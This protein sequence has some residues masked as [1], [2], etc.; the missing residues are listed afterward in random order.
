MFRKQAFCLAVFFYALVLSWTGSFSACAEEPFGSKSQIS[1]LLERDVASVTVIAPQENIFVGKPLKVFKY[2]AKFSSWEEQKKAS[3]FDKAGKCEFSLPSG[4]FRIEV[5]TTRNKGEILCARSQSFSVARNPVIVTLDKVQKQTVLL[6][7]DNRLVAINELAVASLGRSE[8]RWKSEKGVKTVSLFTPVGEELE[9]N[10][11]GGNKKA[12]I[13]GW[14]TFKADRKM[15]ISTEDAGWHATA[16]EVRSQL[17]EEGN[18]L[19]IDSVEVEFQFPL[20]KIN[21]RL[22]DGFTLYTNR[23][24]AQMSYVMVTSTKRLAIHKSL[25]DFSKSE[26][27]RL[28]GP[29]KTMPWTA[30]VWGKD[31]GWRI[32]WGDRFLIPTYEKWI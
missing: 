26:V 7:H 28:G 12:V 30:I 18:E 1:D 3:V 15:E 10:V 21:R 2:S 4:E 5:L 6:K 23:R 27:L 20:S 31:N 19:E 25:V 22:E 16:L 8:L 32:R 9:L 24:V 14:Q 29:L 11:V 17:T 13:A